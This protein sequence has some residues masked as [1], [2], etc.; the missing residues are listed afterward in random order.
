MKTTIVMKTMTCKQLGGACDMAFQASTFEEIA[1]MSKQHGNEMLEAQD[2]AHL[3][4]MRDMKVLM[5]SPE[6]LQ[7][8]FE[9]KRR[10]F[11]SLPDD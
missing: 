6:T 3:K 10:E 1:A 11:E 4:A 8:W 9:S 7:A 5:S 2:E